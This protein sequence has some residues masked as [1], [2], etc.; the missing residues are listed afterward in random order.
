MAATSWDR[1]IETDPA[2]E[3]ITSKLLLLAGSRSPEVWY[4][5]R[6]IAQL[7]LSMGNICQTQPPRRHH[8]LQPSASRQN[9]YYPQ[10]LD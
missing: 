8:G 9:R 2:R 3:K 7:Q 1:L 4:G 5:D 10:K 6:A